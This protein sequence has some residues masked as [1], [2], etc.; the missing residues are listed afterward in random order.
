M[1]ESNPADMSDTIA[2]KFAEMEERFKAVEA[3]KEAEKKTRV[4]LEERLKELE[5]RMEAPAR[6][7]GPSGG[8]M[9][10]TSTGAAGSEGRPPPSHRVSMLSAPNLSPER[11]AQLKAAGKEPPK[12]N[13]LLL[14]ALLMLVSTVPIGLT[15]WMSLALNDKRFYW[16]SAALGPVSQVFLVSHIFVT[17][18]L[19]ENMGYLEIFHLVLYLIGKPV[20]TVLVDMKQHSG[21]R[22][23]PVIGVLIYTYPIYY[24]LNKVRKAVR[25][26][27]LR[28]DTLGEYVDEFFTKAIVSDAIPMIFL[29]FV[30]VAAVQ[31]LKPHPIKAC[32]D[33]CVSEGKT[34][35]DLDDDEEAAERWEAD[36]IAMSI[37]VAD[38]TMNS[39]L[40]YLLFAYICLFGTGLANQREF[41]T[42]KI[43]VYQQIAGTCLVIEGLVSLY[44]Q[45]A[46]GEP[47]T[48]GFQLMYG[49]HYVASVVFCLSLICGLPL[50][51]VI[52]GDQVEPA[53][54]S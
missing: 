19:T 32:G 43:P 53:A 2:A 13:M 31:T 16:I 35:E 34:W 54:A 42:F 21:I 44:F 40:F 23:F 6:T 8:A 37:L 46:K 10:T 17:M 36:T 33:L 41:M 38:S 28:E 30:S 3:E 26:H 24:I 7:A 48:T 20:A 5:T 52:K 11:L 47:M 1:S 49:I 45:A 27:Q 9:T 29:T 12:S 51:K 50:N 39:T 25:A 14:R 22:V 4:A 15:S 18:E